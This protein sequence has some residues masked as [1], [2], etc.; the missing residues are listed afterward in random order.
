LSSVV[1]SSYQNLTKV[2]MI[3]KIQTSIGGDFTNPVTVKDVNFDSLETLV[4]TINFNVKYNVKNEVIEVGELSTM[5]VPYYNLFIKADAFQEETRTQELNYWQYE[6]CD[7]Y[8]EDITLNLPDGKQFTDVPKSVNLSYN[9]TQY[10]L[11][12]EK[13]SAS[14]IQVTRDIKANRSNIPVAEY[15]NFRKFMDDILAA[16]AKYIA[17]K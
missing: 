16:E 13:K 6:D 4:D 3:E 11:K 2:K 7:H 17:F 14:V 8:H 9:G 5:K 10:S 12:F 15:P 1:R